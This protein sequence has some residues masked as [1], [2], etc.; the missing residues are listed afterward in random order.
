[1]PWCGVGSAS[2]QSIVESS[3]PIIGE[4]AFSTFNHVSAKSPS[5]NHFSD[6][7]LNHRKI[8][9]YLTDLEEFALH[10]NLSFQSEYDEADR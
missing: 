10:S 4:N 8:D 9:V 3:C 1:M 5:R 7:A 2:R 6:H